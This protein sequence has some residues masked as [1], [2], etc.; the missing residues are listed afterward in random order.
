MPGSVAWVTQRSLLVAHG[1]SSKVRS[2][3]YPWER[4]TV[5][6]PNTIQLGK[7]QRVLSPILPDERKSG[8][9]DRTSG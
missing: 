9:G 7:V 5:E 3:F 1:T 4:L 8:N 2:Y 6:R